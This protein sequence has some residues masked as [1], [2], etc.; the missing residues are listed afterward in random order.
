MDKHFEFNSQ[1]LQVGE[2]TKSSVCDEAH[3]VVPDVQLVQH[4]EAH[5]AGFLQSGQVVG[6]QVATGRQQKQNNYE[7]LYQFEE[8]L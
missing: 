3:A 7:L 1:H 5:E 4:A 6:G 8:N 2:A